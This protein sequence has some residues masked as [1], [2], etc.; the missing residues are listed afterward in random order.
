MKLI[1]LSALSFTL[2]RKNLRT[3]NGR[4]RLRWLYGWRITG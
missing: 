4:I 1:P 2:P 3:K